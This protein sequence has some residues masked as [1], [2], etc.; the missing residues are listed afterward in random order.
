VGTVAFS[1]TVSLCPNCL[2]PIRAV[3]YHI[4]RD[5][6]MSKVCP[7]HGEFQV[8]LWRGNPLYAEWVR[9]KVPWHP[10]HPSTATD[11][12]CPLDC[13]LCPDHRQQTCTALLEVT[14]RCN[15]GCAVCF[16]GSGGTPGPDP[17]MKE[18][19]FWYESLSMISP[20]SNVQLSGGEPTIRD[21]LPEIAALGRSIGFTFIQVNT[22]GLRLGTDPR[23]VE[24]LREAGVS[25]VFLQFDGTTDD[26]HRRL[27]RS[28]ILQQKLAA[29]RHCADHDIGVVLVPTV[30]PGINDQDLGNLLRFAIDHMPVVR[31]IH[32]QP[33]SY[34]GR[35]PRPPT[36]EDRI[37][38]PEVIREL[39]RQTDGLVKT[40]DF[41]PPGCENAHCS[42]HGTFVLMPDGSLRA[43]SQD[44]SGK[45]S[46]GEIS[47]EEGAAAARS[48]VSRQWVRPELTR[49]CGQNDGPSLG[50][51]DTILERARTYTLSISGMA[52]Q[53]AWN[54]DTERVKDCCIH[55]VDRKGRLIPF[56]AFNVTGS[57][58]RTLYRDGDRE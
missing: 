15:L 44:E 5:V 50:Y 1:E 23:F 43:F 56:C 6:Y 46:C 4:G 13:G 55:V 22:N 33:V 32:F 47:A 8:I 20:Q 29:I 35:Y 3:I 37:T 57:D 36:D 54:I 39:E 19:R 25:S 34:F 31:G 58:G 7:D 26:I 11:K 9:P 24:R 40:V 48:F 38:I 51:W 27:R 17:D 10:D 53:D 12:G 41:S 2:K 18:I 30:V 14:S 16:A 28:S 45:C 52:F 21:D 42:F 49:C